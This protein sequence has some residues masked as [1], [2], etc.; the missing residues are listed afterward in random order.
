MDMYVDIPEI[1]SGDKMAYLEPQE[2]LWR[3]ES[4][5]LFLLSDLQGT[6]HLRPFDGIAD[7]N[8]QHTTQYSK[9]IF[10]FP[11]RTE[12][13]D[14]SK[15]VYNISKVN[16]LVNALKLEAK[17]L[18][19]FLRSVHTIEV[20]SIDQYNKRL[21]FQ[22][23]ISGESVGD[24]TQKRK[25][26]LKELKSCYS[27]R[28]FN[29]TRVFEFT[30]KFDV[31]VYDASNRQ[32]TTSH[33]LVAN[34]VGSS[35]SRVRN[36]SVQ[37]KVFPWVGTAVELG[38]PGNG[39][40]FCF[41]PMPI[42]TASNLP[43]H[44]NGTFGLNDDRRNLKWPGVERRNDSTADWNKLLVSEVIPSCYVR[45]LLEAK[46]HLSIHET[47]F[48]YKAWPDVTSLRGT[49]WEKLLRPV[50]SALLNNNVIWSEN[51]G[52]WV[53]PDIAC[54]VPRSKRLM[55]IIERILTNC[56]VK[57]AE[58]PGGIW[59][60]FSYIN[61]SV[62]EVSP[63]FVRDQLRACPQ[64]YA[65]ID[66]TGKCILLRY[67]M[68][69]GQI[70]DLTGLELLPLANGS[71][72]TFQVKSHFIEDVFLCT[73]ECPRYLLPNL[74]HRL[75]D[76][77][78]NDPELHSS[79][80][81]VAT[82]KQ[83]QLQV[84]DIA[85]VANLL[86][87]AMPPEWK[88]SS[89]ISFP[90]RQF[91]FDWV[92]KFWKW[93]QNKNLSYFQDK[94]VVPVQC[95]D[96]SASQKY[97]LVKLSQSQPHLYIPHYSSVSDI[98]L[99]VLNKFDIMYSPQSS[100]EFL[101]H[102]QLTSF[103]GEYSPTNILEVI[104]MK[105]NYSAVELSSQ[106]AECLRNSL[107][108]ARLSHSMCEALKHLR[109]FQSTE[110][111]ASKLYSV[112]EVCH[113]SCFR[114]AIIKPS[115]TIDTSVL[116]S[117]FIFFSSENHY[118][119]QLLKK[120]SNVNSPDEVTFLQS[121]I[122]LYI[123]NGSINESC[124]DALMT[125]VLERFHRVMHGITI[126]DLEFVKVAS[127]VRKCPSELFDPSNSVISQ[128]FIGE[129]VF[130]CAPYNTTKYINVLKL[131]GLQTSIGAQKILD[132]IFSISLKPSLNPLQVDQNRLICA[133][134][135]FNYIRSDILCG[136]LRGSS[137]Q[138]NS[139]IHCGF[140]SF[141]EALHKI[142]SNRSW[143]PVLA[144]RPSNYPKCLPWK[145]TGY[146]SHF[147]TLNNSVC[148]TSNASDSAPLLYGSQMFFTNPPVDSTVFGWLSYR[149]HP[150]CLVPHLQQVIAH[151]N[152]F[153]SINQ[154]MDVLKSIYAAMNSCKDRL[155][156]LKS[157]KEWV[158]IKKYNKF[159]SVDKVALEYNPGFRHNVEPYL[160]ILPDSISEY[161]QLFASFGMN[162]NFSQTQILSILAVMKEEISVNQA[163]VTADDAWS[164]VL[165][166]LNWLTV[167]G[168]KE[169]DHD[170]VYVP[171][172][173]DT[174]WP[175]LREASELV[176]TDNDF[177]K[178]FIDKE[179]LTFVHH[180]ITPSMAKCLQITPLT[181]ELDV[182]EDT[183]GEAG[184]H[185]PLIV[186]LKNILKDYKDGLTII[187]ELIQNADD[188]EATEVNICYDA[189][190]H[191]TERHRLFFPGMC[192]SH[193][194]ALVIHNNS[195][196]RDE[197]FANIQKLAAATKQDKDL[198]IG[199]FGIGFCSVYHI[200]DVPSFISRERLYIFDP[201]LKHLQKEVKNA[202][203][204]GKMVKFLCKVIKN[205]RQMD[206][207]HGLFG[208]DVNSEYK[209]TMFRLPFRTSFSELSTTCY[210]ESAISELLNSL[211]KCGDKLL[212]FLRH[213]NHITFQ[214]ICDGQNSPHLLY[215]LHKTTVTIP[216]SLN[217]SMISIKSNHIRDAKRSSN[218]W[219]VAK[220]EAVHNGKSAVAEVACLLNTKEG[221]YTVNSELKGEIFCYLPLSQATGLPVHASCNFAVIS[222]RRGIW[223]SSE[224]DSSSHPE[225]QWNIYLMEKII[226]TAYVKGLISL[227]K[228]HENNLLQDY[229]FYS[230]WPLTSNLK[231]VNP[232]ESFVSALYTILS[233]KRLLYSESVTRWLTLQ[234]S[235]FLESN[236]FNQSGTQPCVLEILS[237]LGQPVVHLPSDYR[238][239]FKDTIRSMI[240][241]EEKFTNLVFNNLTRLS[242]IRSSRN[243]VMCIMLEAYAIQ[244]DDKTQLGRVLQN[245]LKNFSCI[246]CSYDEDSLRKCTEVVHPKAKFA[247]LF[248]ESENR[249]PINKLIERHLATTA[250]KHAGMLQDTIPWELLIERAQT[251]ESVLKT[252][253]SKALKRVRFILAAMSSCVINEPPSHGISIDTIPFLPVMKK[254][255][256]YPLD[257]FIENEELLCG[258]QLMSSGDFVKYTNIDIAGSQVAFICDKFPEEGGCGYLSTK[259]KKL[260]NLR[261]SPTWTEVVVHL[262]TIIKQFNSSSP[263]SS[264]WVD[265]ACKGVYNFIEVALEESENTDVNIKDV[266]NISCIWNGEKF[267][268]VD[269][270]ALEWKLKNG[271]YLYAAPPIVSTHKKLTS[272]LEI[273]KTFSHHDAQKALEMMQADFRDTPVDSSC[274]ELI[275][276][277]IALLQNV[278]KDDLRKLNIR[279]PDRTFSLHKSRDLAYN[280]APWAPLHERFILVHES[281]PRQLAVDLGIKPVRSKMLDQYASKKTSFFKGTQFGQREELTSRIKNIIR[282]YPL[283]VTILKELLQNADDA[284]ATK[285]YIILDKRFHGTESVISEKWQ[286]I[287]GPALLIWN[288]STFTEKDL[289][290]IQELGIGSKRSDTESIGQYGIG[291]NVVYHLTDCPSFISGGETL[292]IL[293]PHTDYVPGADPV[294]PGRR[295]DDLK[296]GFWE[297]FPNMSSAYLQV[298][299][300]DAPE[301][302]L[303]GSLFRFPIRHSKDMVD[304]SQIVEDTD[305]NIMSPSKLSLQISYWMTQIKHAMFF[306][307]NMTDI[308]FLEI[309]RD[310]KKLET[311]FHYKMEIPKSPSLTEKFQ[312]LNNTLSTFTAES[313]CESC[314][315]LYPLTLTEMRSNIIE[316]WLIQQGVGDMKNKVQT[317][318]YVRTVKPRHGIA[319]PL[320]I[321]C[322]SSGR[323]ERL[324]GQLFCFLPL[325]M[326]SGVP[327]HVNG[328]FILDSNRR[329]LWKCTNP[330]NLDDRSLWN[331]NLFKAISSSYADF[332][333]HARSYYLRED[334]T[335]WPQ[336]LN[337]LRRYYDNFPIVK[338]NASEKKGLDALAYNVYQ[339]LLEAN[340]EILCVLSSNSQAKSAKPI[341]TVSWW[342]LIS[343]MPATQVYFWSNTPGS[344]RKVIQPI[345]ESLKMKITSASPVVLGI[346]NDALTKLKDEHKI[347]YISPQAV[348][349]YYTE[350]SSF[351]STRTMKNS[352]ITN[353]AFTD[354][355][356]F[357]LFVKYLLD[358]SL[359]DKS[360]NEKSGSHVTQIFPTA[361]TGVKTHKFPDSPF[362]HFLL[363]SADGILRKFN[364]KQKI[365]NSEYFHLFPT[366]PNKFLHPA[367]REINFH[368]SYFI[369]CNDYKD[370]KRVFQLILEIFEGTFP[371]VMKSAKIIN[372]ASDV[373]AREKLVDY[374]K[375]FSKDEVF[376]SYIRDFLKY[377]ALLLTVDGR[378]FSTS[379]DI[380]PMYT[381]DPEKSDLDIQ[382][383]HV[384]MKKLKMPF[385]DTTVVKGEVNCPKFFEHYRILS[386]I[387]HTDKNV[388][389][390]TSI[391]K[392]E[393]I[394]LVINYLSKSS[395]SKEFIYFVRC[396][397]FFEDVAGKYL[398]IDGKRAHIWPQTACF[399]GYSKWLNRCNAIF[400]NEYGRWK[401]LGSHEQFSI[402]LISTE[403]LYIQYIFPNFDKL[404]ESERFKHLEHIRDTMF[405]TCMAYKEIKIYKSTKEPVR[406][407][408]YEAQSFFNSLFN[409]KCIGPSGSILQP[410][411]AFSDHKV[412]IFQIFSCKFQVLPVQYQ[413]YKWLEF[414][415]KLGL[416]RTLDK[417]E[418][419][420]L[421]NKTACGKMWNTKECSDVLIKYIFSKEIIDWW[422]DGYFLGQVSRIPFVFSADISSVKWILPGV[423]PAN[424]L[425]KLNGSA[426]N[427]LTNL[428]WTVR[429]IVQLPP[430]CVQLFPSKEITSMLQTMNIC[431]SKNNA[432]KEDVMFNLSNI[433]KRSPYSDE[434]LFSNYP[435]T[436][437]TSAPRTSASS[438][439][440]MS[441]TDLIDVI[442]DHLEFLDCHLSDLSV[443]TLASLPCIPVHC[444]LS[445]KDRRKVVLVRPSC[446]VNTTSSEVETYHP[447][448]H[449]LPRELRETAAAYNL[450]REIGIKHTLELHHMQIVLEK[451]FVS[452][453]QLKLDCNTKMCVKKAINKLTYLLPR[454]RGEI[455]ESTLVSSLSPLYLPNSEDVLQLST[456][457]LYGDTPSYLGHMH[458]D[459]SGTPYSHFDI[460]EEYYD[461][462]ALDV[463]RLLPKQVCPL[464]MSEKC[465]QVPVEDCEATTNSKLAE[466][467]EVLLQCESNPLATV[468]FIQKL[469]SKDS[470]DSELVSLIKKFLLSIKIITTES[471][472]TDIVLIKSVSTIGQVN[473]DYYLALSGS[474]TILYLDSSN[475]TDDDILTE[476][477]E[478]IC[479]ITSKIMEKNISPDSKSKLVTSIVRYF[480]AENP[481]QK[482]K[483]LE[484]YRIDL[485]VGDIKNFTAN[486]GEEIPLCYHH[487]LDQDIHNVYK[488]ME[489]VGYE[490]IEEKIIMAQIVHLVESEAD[491]KPYRTYR[492]YTKADDLCGKVVSIFELYKFLVRYRKAKVSPVVPKDDTKDDNAALVPYDAESMLMNLQTSLLE[493]DL[494]EKKKAI[495]REL[496]E[497]WQLGSGLKRKALRRLYLRWHPDNLDDPIKAEKV[498]TFLMRQIENLD[499]NKPLDDPTFDYQQPQTSSSNRSSRGLD[500]NLWNRTAAR[501]RQTYANEQRCSS[502]SSYQF[503]FDSFVNK[504]DPEEGKHLVQQAEV[505]YT[506]LIDIYS[507]G[508]TISRYGHVCIMA[509]QVAEKALKGAVYAV[510]GTDGRYL[511]DHN[512]LRHANALHMAKSDQTEGL[513][514][515]CSPLESY[516]LDP[517]YPHR[518]PRYDIPSDHYSLEQ[519][520]EARDHAR[521]VLDIVQSIMN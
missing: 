315:I 487:R 101:K 41:L 387:Y 344:E 23:K 57:L 334:Y 22:S 250:M 100:F 330:E 115:N 502:S 426:S 131:C 381:P 233:S 166:I 422:Q 359:T 375:C 28:Q 107:F 348:F 497:I 247:C 486:L 228:M 130:P 477:A 406:C 243:D 310:S 59:D 139:L 79:L 298:G 20:Y 457:M 276:E 327:V 31:C 261:S 121:Y 278:N 181:K 82:H 12:P 248:D 110:N 43:V 377:W 58:V 411:R 35:N 464:G 138:V 481:R 508:T 105:Y 225:V 456:S 46:N 445:D 226:P 273:K 67:C 462:N 98:M 253:H 314:V 40:I 179:P 518:W 507:K 409:L 513:V 402:S 178:E 236:I 383:V 26:L 299:I 154:M 152:E 78:V 162:S 289:K 385:L 96:Q 428:L 417:D 94:L 246:P 263:P 39:R 49:Q 212:M 2:K 17:L 515:H 161:F 412:K 365:L 122:F 435:T 84:L 274:R 148:M 75:V 64:S 388:I 475:E 249:F 378:L 33:W 285:M 410:I 288:N 284:K 319:A 80:S 472:R 111:T 455:D 73:S 398:P 235:E 268:R 211:Y 113:Q 484:K 42:E 269:S 102:Q 442:K 281:I 318:Q 135:V 347:P 215:E 396:L 345:L 360:T 184:Q 45:I 357:L 172:E 183:F 416:R 50:F 196:F 4:G 3:G 241:T 70:N 505:D 160:H 459:L 87:E 217:A 120:L 265:K 132:V 480:K 449:S 190:R 29:F 316:E 493:D 346:F 129:D 491:G 311:R 439:K 301:E 425:V 219:L 292:C 436:L 517:H 478:H 338:A 7:F 141:S 482:G 103:I 322:D 240:I 473:T 474:Q 308:K 395:K 230:L 188:A 221:S 309:E 112:V 61:V 351:S 407:K 379:S 452:S 277:L 92:K 55:R 504:T 143:L 374:W 257:W 465:K 62:R 306:L 127:G 176:Y 106:E 242:D 353:T 259:V 389:P 291:F 47:S 159:V 72:T 438:V 37:Q 231:Q 437:V 204:P 255:E 506:V 116:P 51:F 186:R 119:N 384:V 430:V 295:F 245:Y 133:K 516:Y 294:N 158:Y 195:V 400:V 499:A 32:T 307:H 454:R 470:N 283:D 363:L 200:T 13:S 69:D 54:Y 419:L 104:P 393:E 495:C 471:L 394:D 156:G 99:S 266:Q 91:P 151:K 460:D 421:C 77:S 382:K 193:G 71:F 56:K 519:A 157:I 340:A 63:K 214:E 254:P 303:G 118:Q 205:S 153:S 189:R 213:I 216:L 434:N 117:N 325:P 350:F 30:A 182:S 244:F 175:D 68:S 81:Q 302:L 251:V 136:N 423:Y 317:W 503:P 8:T 433:C 337:D 209:G 418:Y 366:Y 18:L 208:F 165:G 489:Y 144:K 352:L 514:D 234:E 321:K 174:V 88:R 38:N 140:L 286:E 36:A 173:S 364:E 458:I 341:I 97:K 19:L 339:R 34:Q 320:D 362:S 199:K 25:S 466:K 450:L 485:N 198:K 147:A 124:V 227:Q 109:V 498:F 405:S 343:Q 142:S 336:A 512:L 467:L 448:L 108:Q 163:S 90:N 333:T 197:D 27:S 125:Q 431:T 21:S 413:T 218:I 239:Q 335:S 326:E 238:S 194:P 312:T 463:C 155:D 496:K 89:Y 390:L 293:D 264:Q 415:S 282:D 469:V 296:M 145:G 501:H 332:F 95:P 408:I 85:S 11:L 372:K 441:P 349:K 432:T 66:P 290:G 15:N 369:N 237:H 134:A 6:D 126:Q 323:H 329:D 483:C 223:T 192:E 210:S 356:T 171:A 399:V 354:V 280:D 262:K 453:K 376:R 429:P 380:L 397:P 65:S 74:D 267:L 521:A 358:I 403:Q 440:L 297:Q 272:F 427:N 167:N 490:I 5:R 443:E 14:L 270:I 488:P 287:Q 331:V 373:I 275:M 304:N 260:L 300:E 271:P 451:A 252:D 177:L 220:H 206:P 510:C 342:P 187:K 520:G 44:I 492:I 170:G 444:D 164:T 83:T 114:R 447:F 420:D 137:Y 86:D 370:R 149:N 392:N 10:R 52:E 305:N 386:N 391:L 511:S 401:D 201:T 371:Q 279:L 93:V 424:Q 500:Y 404:D 180:C 461:I 53:I 258:K 169:V 76:L 1:I 229:S 414:F 509:H 476:I 48:F 16:E 185:E 60:A 224:V 355:N 468:K 123:Q 202:A 9:T 494:I 328:N 368:P 324:K 150:E 232:W 361:I 446:V 203:Q 479:K 168:T 222:N 146:T 191:T 313:G 207:Y 128:I 367:L 24:I 256:G